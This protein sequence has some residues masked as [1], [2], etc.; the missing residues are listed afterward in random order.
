[1]KGLTLIEIIISI[2]VF[3]LIT[4]P[5]MNLFATVSRDT[6]TGIY[7]NRASSMA[8][9]YMELVLSRSFD[10]EGSSPF[11]DPAD[12]G[13][14]SGETTLTDYDDVDDFNGYSFV[15]S[16]YP[17]ITVTVSVYYVNNPDSSADWDSIAIAVTDYKRIDILANHVQFDTITV[18]NGVSY[19]GHNTK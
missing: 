9:S 13:P 15:D 14:D 6:D 16:D 19:A 5:L 1:M 11:T 7:I 8:A 2:V 10:E 12:L 18:S 17:N 3:V 4:I